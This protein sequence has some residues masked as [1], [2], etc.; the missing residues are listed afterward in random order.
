MKKEMLKKPIMVFLDEQHD[1][2]IQTIQSFGNLV[3]TVLD[4]TAI[5]NKKLIWG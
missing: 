2:L 5:K 4:Y 3:V 1:E